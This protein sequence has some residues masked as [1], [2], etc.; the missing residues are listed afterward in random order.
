[1]HYKNI[2]NNRLVLLYMSVHCPVGKLSSIKM[3]VGTLQSSVGKLRTGLCAASKIQIPN[4]AIVFVLNTIMYTPFFL[5]INLNFINFSFT[6]PQKI[7]GVFIC[8]L[9]DII[10]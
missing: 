1:M 5:F 7:R 2:Q 10:F 3:K 4:F 9:I 6:F 8:K